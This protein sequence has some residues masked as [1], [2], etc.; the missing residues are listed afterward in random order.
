MYT[1]IIPSLGRI[2]YLNELLQSIYN[3]TILPEEIIILLDRNNLCEDSEKL[4]NQKKNCKV[5]FCNNLNLSQKRNYGAEIT[6]TNYIIYSDDDDIWELNKG[7]LTIKSLNTSQIVCHEYTKFGEI[8]QKPKF[9]LGK[10]PRIINSKDLL[11]GSNIFGGG[12]GIAGRREIFLALPFDKNYLFCEDFY[13]W[14]KVVLAEIKIEYL[15]YPLVKYRTHKNNMTSNFLKIYFFNIKIFRNL[16]IKSSILFI[17][18]IYGF[19][20]STIKS[21]LLLGI[22]LLFNKSKKK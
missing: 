12:S 2:N 8:D 22:Y 3:Q 5:V 16:I 10:N 4:I 1:V 20:K 14:I 18:S 9:I 17:A 6:K 19:L 11:F 13:W 7:E 15:P 21:F